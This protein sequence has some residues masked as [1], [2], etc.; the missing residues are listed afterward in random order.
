[1]ELMLIVAGIMI[2]ASIGIPI[3][4]SY[5]SK[6]KI[7]A[8]IVDTTSISNTIEIIR[9]YDENLPPNLAAVPGIP[10]LDPWGNPYQYSNFKNVKEKGRMRKNHF[11][12]PINSDCDLYSMG[13][14]GAST[15]PLTAKSSRVDIIRANDGGVVGLASD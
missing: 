14:D 13:E 8:A 2:L 6:A 5:T 12:V 10:P 15:S 7:N 3:Y 11:M 9:L 1:M 4:N